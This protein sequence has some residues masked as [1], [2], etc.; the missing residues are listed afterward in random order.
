MLVKLLVV[1]EFRYLI[2]NLF[3]SFNIILI[4]IEKI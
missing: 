2:I 1:K 4:E 3:I